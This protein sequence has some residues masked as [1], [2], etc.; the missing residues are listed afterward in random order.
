MNNNLLGTNGQT[1]IEFLIMFGYLKKS[2]SNGVI[3]LDSSTFALDKELI[4][5]Y[6]NEVSPNYDKVI[7]SFKKKYINTES[8][9]EKNDSLEEQQGIR[10]VYNYIQL[11]DISNTFNPLIESLQIHKRLWKFRDAKFEDET[12]NELRKNAEEKLKLAKETKNLKLFYEAQNELRDL[13]NMKEKVKIGGQLRSFS[14]EVT[15]QS[16]NFVVPSA[17]EATKFINSLCSKEKLDEFNLMLNGDLINYINYCVKLTTDLIKDQPFNEGNKR[18]F[19]S[20]LNLM[21]KLRNIPPVYINK[22]ERDIYKKALFEGIIDNNYE[23]IIGF[24]YHKICDSIYEL[25]VKPFYDILY[26]N[27]KSNKIRKL[28]EPKKMD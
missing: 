28:I 12:E 19:R 4:R 17:L 21:F 7:T 6:Y 9:V 26:K 15:V 5:L 8:R 22:N 24:Y 16:M 1:R 18:T 25:D 10:E 3:K 13:S 27:E 23:N 14:D 20:L 2:E 11:Y